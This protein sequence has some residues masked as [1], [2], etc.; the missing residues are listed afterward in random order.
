VIMLER[1]ETNSC[2]PVVLSKVRTPINQACIIRY[3]KG[4]MRCH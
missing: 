3:L 1:E 2:E 4:C